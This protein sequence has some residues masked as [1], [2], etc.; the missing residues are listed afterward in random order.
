MVHT[1][2]YN[3]IRTITVQTAVKHDIEPQTI[4]FK[5]TL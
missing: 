5:G 3:L 4:S 2:V 1:L